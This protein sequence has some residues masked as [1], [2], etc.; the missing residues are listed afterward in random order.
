MCY[1]F[2][3]RYSCGHVH[4]DNHKTTLSHCSL[5]DTAL[6]NWHL[7]TN[8]EPLEGIFGPGETLSQPR[9]CPEVWAYGQYEGMEGLEN[10]T[11]RDDRLKSEMGTFLGIVDRQRLLH[12]EAKIEYQSLKEERTKRR[13]ARGGTSIRG[14]RRKMKE[15]RM[16][17]GPHA[18]MPY[19]QG[20]LA[21][22]NIL[23]DVQTRPS[24][25]PNVIVQEVVWGC[26]R[27]SEPICMVGHAGPNKILCPWLLA[28]RLN[29]SKQMLQFQPGIGSAEADADA[30]LILRDTNQRGGAV[31]DFVNPD[32][33]QMTQLGIVWD[34]FAD[35][36]DATLTMQHESATFSQ[37]FEG[38]AVSPPPPTPSPKSVT[39]DDGSNRKEIQAPNQA[40]Q[41]Y[42]D[43]SRRTHKTKVKAAIIPTKMYQDIQK[44]IPFGPILSNG[45]IVDKWGR[46]GCPSRLQKKEEEGRL[47]PSPIIQI[48]D[49][50]YTIL[51]KKDLVRKH[52]DF[53]QRSAYRGQFHRRGGSK[54]INVHNLPLRTAR[55]P[56]Q[57]NPE[58]PEFRPAAPFGFDGGSSDPTSDETPAP[59]RIHQ[60]RPSLSQE[61]VRAIRSTTPKGQL[62]VVGLKDTSET[63]ETDSGNYF[64]E[65]TRE[66]EQDRRVEIE[67]NE[68]GPRQA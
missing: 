11:R 5:F 37:D 68:E 31:L 51:D 16:D 14:S 67:G 9:K 35:I 13:P 52:G 60:S 53:G 22:F 58:A 17:K 8:Y 40:P 63:S 27:H 12:A 4:C 15:E 47:G 7:Q 30:V 54:R 64:E 6:R 59:K 1:Y 65:M 50:D 32:R 25:R 28:M 39:G 62:E 21:T 26:G 3:K 10:R 43:P 56:S 33:A 41:S 20:Y 29:E 38:L 48:T 2:Y 42:H 23:R 19:P 49:H 18:L 55:R 24:H 45:V 66:I 44:R 61:E 34:G 46:Y 36:D 57:P